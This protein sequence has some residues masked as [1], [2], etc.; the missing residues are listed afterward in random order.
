MTIFSP[1]G[2][3][4]PFCGLYGITPE[5]QDTV[6]LLAQVEKALGAGLR[7]LQY[8]DKGHDA[9]Q[10][11]ATARALRAAC[12]RHGARLI[13]NDD[14]ELALAVGADGVHLG[15]TDGS[16]AAARARLG[17]DAL[18]GASC[19]NR[20]DL[21]R[22]AVAAGASYVAFGAVCP[23]ATKPDAVPCPLEVLS[24]AR[25]TLPVP[26]CAIGGITLAS[27]PAIL[28]AGADLLA[29]ISD[30]FGNSFASGDI[31]ARVSAY[32]S[33]FCQRSPNDLP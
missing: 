1:P 24:R 28:A 14:P 10:R 3:P 27:A 32:Q 22:A 9:S 15:Q 13:I 2:S 23:S 4:G 29:V 26:V 21:A 20:L 17:P 12:Q 19:Y 33:L 25:A 31:A 5:S 8:R 16:I 30:L 11:L 7:C 6:I 18:I